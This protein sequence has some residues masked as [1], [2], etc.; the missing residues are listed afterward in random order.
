MHGVTGF[1]ESA[2]LLVCAAFMLVTFC[3]RIGVP[4]IV[5]YIFAGIVVGPAG[6]NLVA[7]SEALA[8]IGEIGVVLL[9]FALGLEFSFERL[10]NLRRHVFG[11]GALQVVITTATVSLV[12][13]LTFDLAPVSAIL[14]GGAI[15]MSSTAMCLK[16]LASVNALGTAHGRLAIAVLLFQDLAAVAFLLLHDSMSGAVEGYGM[17]TVAA[18]A[19][20][21]VAALFIARSSLQVLVRWVMSH[22]DPE[23][24]QLLALAIALGS[25]MVAASAGLSP[26][27]AAFAAGMI[28]GEGDARHAVENEIRPFRDLFVGI[29][30]IGI[31][32]QLP[33][34]LIPSVWPIVL[35]W[36]AIVL[37]GKTLIVL[38]VA[39]L[40]GKPLQTSWRTAIILAHGGEFS[41]MLLSV[42][43]RSGIVAE[44]FVGP[45]LLAIG[46]SILVGS[47]MVRW[48]GHHSQNDSPSMQSIKY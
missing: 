28:I 30:F 34:W 19:A 29:F 38:I 36:L 45:I 8:G 9:L 7:E 15:A 17:I 46:A 12:A 41:L 37:V 26:A 16:V 4:S 23:L 13:S 33:L 5:G 48:A 24:A 27:L 39:R 2:A 11:L 35:V 1:L 6:L 18:S 40:F 43:S 20:A 42:S 31:G 21:L 25:A 44:Q 10:V 47:L 22:G 14:V 3:S 32:T